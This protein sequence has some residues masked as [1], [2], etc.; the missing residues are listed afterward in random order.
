[1][2]R[3][4][5]YGVLLVATSNPGLADVLD[6]LTGAFIGTEPDGWTEIYTIERVDPEVLS[7]ASFRDTTFAARLDGNGSLTL[8]QGG[9]GTIA[10]NNDLTL[11]PANG[12]T[13]RLQ[14]V[15]STDSSLPLTT[16]PEPYSPNPLFADLWNIVELNVNPITGELLPQADGSDEFRDTFTLSIQPSGALRFNDSNNVWYQGAMSLGDQNL[17]RSIKNPVARANGMPTSLGP[18]DNNFPRDVLAWT[19]FTDANTFDGAILLQTLTP[20]DFG[21]ADRIVQFLLPISGTRRQP[22]PVGDLDGDRR[23]GENDRAALIDQFGLSPD[24]ASYNLA[25]DLDGDRYVSRLDLDQFDGTPVVRKTIGP[26]LSGLWFDPNRTGEGFHILIQ[27]ASSAVV[28]WFTYDPDEGQAWVLGTAR[29]VDNALVL[30]DIIITRGARFGDDFDGADLVETPWGDGRLLF[31]DCDNGWVGYAGTEDFGNG[32]YALTRLTTPVGLDCAGEQVRTD[33]A[34]GRYTGIWFDPL[35]SGAGWFIDELPNQRAALTWFTY[36]AHGNQRWMV[37][38]GTLGQDGIVID[39]LITTSGARFGANF[40][41]ASVVNIPWGSLQMTSSC[42]GGSLS[43]QSLDATS[44]TQ[45]IVP[46]ARIAGH[47]C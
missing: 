15:F 27:D 14:R 32:G 24:R 26:W 23:V 43:Y 13:V 20:G 46:L 18:S 29:I 36:D 19:Q 22:L 31:D 47:N 12:T 9:S 44:G 5:P 33:S 21:V 17:V 40:D 39:D 8:V 35:Q 11:F 38:N 10:N 41:P 6:D 45:A 2:I 28:A 4:V 42:Q 25:A 34:L 30:D 3:L 37:G 1:M 16:A 7:I